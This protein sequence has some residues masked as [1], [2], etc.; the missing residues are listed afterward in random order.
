MVIVYVCGDMVV[1]GLSGGLLGYS[2]FRDDAN[3]SLGDAC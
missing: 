2:G 3:S 1:T